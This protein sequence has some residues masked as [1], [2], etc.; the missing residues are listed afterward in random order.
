MPEATCTDETCSL[1]NPVSTIV[2]DVDLLFA[3]VRELEK[4]KAELELS[5]ERYKGEM[6]GKI[7]NFKGMGKGAYVAIGAVCSVFS[8][9]ATLAA[10]FIGG[11]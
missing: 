10:K 8:F 5:L 11:T 3:R 2:K 4:D 1:R 9:L 7:E 6:N